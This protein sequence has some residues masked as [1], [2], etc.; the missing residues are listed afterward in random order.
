MPDKAYER[1]EH[2]GDQEYGQA[3]SDAGMF[4]SARDP[5]VQ[6]VGHHGECE[7]P[8]DRSQERVHEPPAKGQK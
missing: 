5:A 4:D 3:S 1:E 6:R 2:E 8:C 7:R